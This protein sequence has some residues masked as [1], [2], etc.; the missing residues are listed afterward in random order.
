MLNT[1]RPTI[2]QGGI[3]GGG[4]FMG[5]TIQYTAKCGQ[6]AG[7]IGNTFCT[8]NADESGTPPWTVPIPAEKGGGLASGA[9][10][11]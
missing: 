9:H 11:Q 4:E 1:I 3:V 6:T 10:R 8:Y 7:P 2:H 5:S